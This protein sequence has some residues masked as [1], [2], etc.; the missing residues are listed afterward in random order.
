MQPTLSTR[1]CCGTWPSE[2][3]RSVAYVAIARKYRP[4][5][6]EEMVG[7]E[8]VTRTLR[9]ALT[10]NRIH[11]AFLFS[12]TRGVGKTTTARAF[13]R[14]LNC[15]DGPTPTPCGTC[16]SCKGIAAGSSPDLIEIDG[17]SNNSVDDM[18]EI[19]DTVRYLPT[20]G[21]YKIYLI[22]EVHMLSRAAFNALLLS[23]IHI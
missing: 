5:T 18:R 6:F 12:G 4:T 15:T 19:R 21:A 16:V 3:E 17:A 10:R 2:L 7:Q 14:A 9:H 22:D 20:Q 11:H 23:L 13:A 8:H 1:P